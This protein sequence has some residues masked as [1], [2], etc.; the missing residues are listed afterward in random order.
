MAGSTGSGS[1]ERSLVSIF[2]QNGAA[3]AAIIEE[4]GGKFAGIEDVQQ[5][6][7]AGLA[8]SGGVSLGQHCSVFM[9][10]VIDEA[11][12]AESWRLLALC[13]N[14]LAKVYKPD[15]FNINHECGSTAPEASPRV[16]EQQN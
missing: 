13:K 16:P 2:R 3:W 11:V 9:A 10:E 6:G 7:R 8:A 5:L 14:V 4:Q 1:V 15:G 12:S